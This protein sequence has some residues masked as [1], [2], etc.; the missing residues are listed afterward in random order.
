MKHFGVV[1]LLMEFF[2]S[3]DRK[4]FR[5]IHIVAPVCSRYPLL[6]LGVVAAECGPERG[7]NINP[8]VEKVIGAGLLAHHHK[9]VALAVMIH[10]T[11]DALLHIAPAF[12]VKVFYLWNNVGQG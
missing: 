7:G 11:F 9:A 10:K 5:L 8:V 4:V 3:L 2:Q 6:H 1:K 12:L